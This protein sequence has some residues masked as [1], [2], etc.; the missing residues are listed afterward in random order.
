ML[1]SRIGLS[2]VLAPIFGHRLR[3]LS[4]GRV[5]GFRLGVGLLLGSLGLRFS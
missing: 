5:L 4:S 2:V 1:R 3:L